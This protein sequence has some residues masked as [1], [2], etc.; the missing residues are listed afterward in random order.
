MAA[1]ISS[2]ITPDATRARSLLK[3]EIEAASCPRFLIAE[4][5]GD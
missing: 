3:R 1:S 4:D 2:N 5:G